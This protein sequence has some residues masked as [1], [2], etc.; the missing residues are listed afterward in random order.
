MDEPNTRVI[1]LKEEVKRFLPF[2]S[3]PNYD[4]S[5][6]IFDSSGVNFGL[7]RITLEERLAQR[8]HDMKNPLSV[9][10]GFEE[11]TRD[12]DPAFSDDCDIVKAKTAELYELIDSYL[13]K[14]RK[15]NSE[16]IKGIVKELG[17]LAVFKNIGSGYD[18]KTPLGAIMNS[19]VT[20]SGMIKQLDSNND[21]NENAYSLLSLLV[22]KAKNKYFIYSGVKVK[23]II[24]EDLK[25][26]PLNVE[27]FS[28][29]F[30][31][32]LDNGVQ[33]MNYSGSIQL[34]AGIKEDN[35]SMDF[36][37]EGKG[38]PQTLASRLETS[39]EMITYD[40][41]NGSGWG[42]YL[43]KRIVHGYGG[44]LKIA[45]REGSG[46]NMR[47]SIPLKELLNPEYRTQFSHKQ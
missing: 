41:K 42:L 17:D 30:N 29:I 5:C 37:D 38:I 4:S 18:R 19:Y 39:K 23:G 9:L 7:S 36:K 26:H 45:S 22:E 16:E 6:P 15:D 35:L 12:L 43:V 33:A 25:T 44:K 46:T 32:L 47:V 13:G 21:S 10:F 2:S 11:V 28:A 34:S 14:H 31:I 24:K 1:S 27:D 3:Y 40:K 8:L 20:L